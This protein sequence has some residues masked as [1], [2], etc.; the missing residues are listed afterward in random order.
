VILQICREKASSNQSFLSTAKNSVHRI[1]PANLL[2][3]KNYEKEEKCRETKEKQET[4]LPAS[5]YMTSLPDVAVT[6]HFVN[7]NLQ[8]FS[9]LHSFKTI[10]RSS[11]CSLLYSARI[12]PGRCI[13]FHR[14]KAKI[15]DTTP[16]RLHVTNATQHGLQHNPQQPTTKTLLAPSPATNGGEEI[17]QAP[18]P[19]HDRR[20]KLREPT[21]K[22]AQPQPPTLSA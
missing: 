19:C 22:M 20:R 13:R 9:L 15:A 18:K 17:H 10:S 4:L 2:H 3:Q 21:L 7:M 11:I 6:L 12:H 1:K 5:K 14:R 16:R 8:R